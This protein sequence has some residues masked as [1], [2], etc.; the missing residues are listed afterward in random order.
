[1]RPVQ[2][3]A[4]AM[5]GIADNSDPFA[6]KRM[7]LHVKRIENPRQVIKAAESTITARAVD[8]NSNPFIDALAEMKAAMADVQK[9]TKRVRNKVRKVQKNF[10]PKPGASAYLRGAQDEAF[11]ADQAAA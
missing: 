10:A 1:M 9:R 5:H 3:N 2:H 4:I 6:R 8:A 11:R 7:A